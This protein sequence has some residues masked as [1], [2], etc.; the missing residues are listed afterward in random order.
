[1]MQRAKKIGEKI[2]YPCWNLD[3]KI[4]LIT[5]ASRGLGRWISL[6]LSQAGAAVAIT[7]RTCDDLQKTAN[8][9]EAIG[10]KVIAIHGNISDVE[11]VRKIVR[12]TIREFGQI[13][14]LVNNAGVSCRTKFLEVTPDEFDYVSDVNFKGLFF[15]TQAVVREMIKQ[16]RGG[17]IINISSTK[18]ILVRPGIPGTVYSGTKGAVNMFTRS[19]AEEL[20]SFKVSVNAVG[21]GLFATPMTKSTW[22]DP[23]KLEPFMALTPMKTVGVAKDIIGPVIFLASDA[24]DYM[25]G[26]ILYLDGG[27]TVL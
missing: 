19:L 14:V 13:D 10:G 9:I 27:R 23:A 24:S 26:Q 1:M 12:K 6:G 15:M 8:E 20:A 4:A 17:K 16:G 2:R 25:T 22:S 7:A 5:G 21:P 3:G 11:S 18:G